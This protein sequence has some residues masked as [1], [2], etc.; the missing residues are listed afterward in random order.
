VSTGAI[1][2]FEPLVGPY[3][4]RQ[5]WAQTA[6]GAVSEA[7]EPAAVVDTEV[8]R[9][10][11]PGMASVIVELGERTFHLVVGWR[12]VTVAPGVLGAQPGA[13]LGP[14][15]DGEGDVLVYDALAD[16]EL[17]VVL[18][19]AATGGAEQAQ[20]GRVV[21]SLVSHSSLVYDDR[22]LMKCY[23]VIEPRSRPEIE[24]VRR[25]DAAGFKH[26]L[27]PVAHWQRGGRDLALVRAFEP[28]AVEGLALA[29]TSLRDLLA[30]ADA[31]E[32]GAAF[33]DVGLAG[34]DLGPEMR[35]LGE[36]TAE[37]HLALAEAF[38]TGTPPGDA[39]RSAGPAIRVHGDYHLRR[40]MRTDGGWLVAGFGDDPLMGEA[41]GAGS[42]GEGRF[43]SALEDVADLCCSLSIAADEAV[44]FQTPR[45]RPHARLLAHGWERRNVAAFLS[46]YLS[47]S[48]ISRLVPETRED[49]EAIVGGLLATRQL[50]VDRLE[51]QRD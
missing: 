49:V 23:R 46:G 48:G 32:N 50:A 18:L 33:A 15:H 13:V 51:T 34:G 3:L 22:L 21:Q 38:G 39:G 30:H 5:A 20:R 37:M 11:H 44:A 10:E 25:L 12:S 7:N 47:R 27:E 9:T 42:Q 28:G 41:A 26:M 14:S 45:T 24:M 40:V 19:A 8:L 17:V 6:L 2:G 4:A 31:S 43:A 29:H 36:T 1:P 35:R 16:A